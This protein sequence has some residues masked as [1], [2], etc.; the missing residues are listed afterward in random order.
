MAVFLK[1]IRLQKK[2]NLIVIGHRVEFPV[3][4]GLLQL[5]L[6]MEPMFLVQQS[7]LTANTYASISES[8]PA[9]IGHVSSSC[10]ITE[11]QWAM[12]TMNNLSAPP[13]HVNFT[14]VVGLAGSGWSSITATRVQWMF[15]NASSYGYEIEN[16]NDRYNIQQSVWQVVN[17]A[18][19]TTALGNAALNITSSVPNAGSNF[20]MYYPND[21]SVQPFIEYQCYSQPSTPTSWA[22]DC[23]DGKAVDIYGD[24]I[25]NA[26]PASISIPNSSNV[27]EIVVEV[28]LQ[29]IKSRLCYHN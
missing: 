14:K 3:E 16:S 15:C 9:C 4:V 29:R 8:A 28:V 25:K 24:G 22:F 2:L 23:N 10:L 18:S 27:Y 1:Y 5:T 12:C 17:G 7:N 13:A 26:L 20:I 11:V 6:A 19:T 21:G